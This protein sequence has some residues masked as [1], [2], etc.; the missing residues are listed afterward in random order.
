MPPLPCTS[1]SAGA[2]GRA[3]HEDLPEHMAAPHT[4]ITSPGAVLPQLTR[5][6]GGTP[7]SVP[8][9]PPAP[10][11]SLPPYIFSCGSCGP[12]HPSHSSYST[13]CFLFLPTQ[14][15]SVF[16]S[17]ILKIL[18]H[19]THPTPSH[20]ILLGGSSFPTSW[21]QTARSP[22]KHGNW[23]TSFPPCSPALPA[24]LLETFPHLYFLPLFWTTQP[25]HCQPSPKFPPFPPPL[26]GAPPA[27]HP[28]LPLPSPSLAP[29]LPS[30]E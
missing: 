27:S 19:P 14:P 25:L 4:A 16:S 1:R 23:S 13:S 11:P 7:A 30:P 17:L 22:S 2:H 28:S 29:P 10:L 18:F 15:S 21:A 12:S 8:T 3:T 26:P 20:V 9:P 6:P 24:S 5:W